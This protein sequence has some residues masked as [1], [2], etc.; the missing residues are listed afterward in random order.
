MSS[1]VAWTGAGRREGK[2]RVGLRPWP[3]PGWD[4]SGD[5]T[6]I[7]VE[8]PGVSQAEITLEITDGV[9][10]VKGERHRDP[11]FRQDRLLCLECHHGP[12]LRRLSLPSMVD[13]DRVRATYRNGVLE[14]RL[15]KQMERKA[16]II[17]VEAI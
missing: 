7:R 9:L 2:R 6:E 10:T 17:S 11:A 14:I 8:L 13:P 1:P 12:F 5:L 16:Q 4:A 3:G 15:P